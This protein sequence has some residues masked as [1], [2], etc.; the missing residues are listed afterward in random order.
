MSEKVKRITYDTGRPEEKIE[1]TVT[2][3]YDGEQFLVR[4]PK[5]ITDY[6]NIKKGDKIKFTVDVP[7]IA[8]TKEKVLVAEIIE[9]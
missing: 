7:Y 3:S 6:L 2:I 1:K 5:K 9:S 4:L 8:E